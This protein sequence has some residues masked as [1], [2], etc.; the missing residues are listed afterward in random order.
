[1]SVRFFPLDRIFASRPCGCQPSEDPPACL[2]H[3]NENPIYV[4]LF[5][6][7]RGLSPNIHIYVSVSDLSIPRIGPLIWL[8]QN[9]TDRSWKYIN[10]SQMYECRNWETEHNNSV[11]EIT[12]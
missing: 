5:W 9:M 12:V 1:M 4:F 10:L 11:L 2:I 8:Q 6:G 3:C 7:L